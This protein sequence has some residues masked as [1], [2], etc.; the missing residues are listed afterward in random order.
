[1]RSKTLYRLLRLF[2][3]D[4][5]AIQSTEDDTLSDRLAELFQVYLPILHFATNKFANVPVFRLPKSASNIFLEAVQILKSFQQ[6]AGVLG[7]VVLYQNK[8]VA[9]QLNYGLTKQLVVCDPYRIKLPADSVGTPFHLPVG[10]QLLSVFVEEAEVERLRRHNSSLEAAIRQVSAECKADANLSKTTTGKPSKESSGAAICGMKRDVSRIFTVVEENEDAGGVGTVA[11]STDVPDVVRDAVKARHLARLGAVN[12][13]SFVVPPLVADTRPAHTT[14]SIEPPTTNVTMRYYSLGLP[15]MDSDWCEEG[16][17]PRPNSY[18]FN[19]ICDPK[20]PLFRANGLP[21]SQSLYQSRIRRH[22]HR[23]K[24]VDVTPKRNSQYVMS[25]CGVP[26][27]PLMAKLSILAQEENPFESTPSSTTQGGV[28]D[29]G[30]VTETPLEDKSCDGEKMGGDTG[31]GSRLG[32]EGEEGEDDDKLVHQVLYVFGTNNTAILLLI[33]HAATQ[34]PD[35]IH[36]LV[37]IIPDI[38]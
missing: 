18:Y 35:R 22:Y 7:G 31:G 4:V 30:D 25:Q 15:R 32:D 27:T 11:A 16:C 34:D 28:K 17:T 23:L 38:L 6:V 3:Y 29:N 21:A 33:D 10:V 2:H 13:S 37:S 36:S 5:E 19:T 8:V 14:D 9:T 26:L 12:P 24:S 1:M 20:Y